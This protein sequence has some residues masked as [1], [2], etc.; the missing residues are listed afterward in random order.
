MEEEELEE[1]MS[2]ADNSSGI[3]KKAKTQLPPSE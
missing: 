1:E 2:S 3:S